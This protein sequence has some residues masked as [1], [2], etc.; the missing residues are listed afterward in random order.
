MLGL[1]CAALLG[2]P[3]GP[4]RL[5]GTAEKAALRATVRVTCKTGTGSGVVIGRAG[6]VAYVLTAAHV[7]AEPEGLAVETSDPGAAG[8]GRRAFADVTVV[9]KASP[10]RQDLAVL[11]V[12]VNG[13]GLTAVIP[14]RRPT[15][16]PLKTP[17]VAFSAGDDGVK[18][19]IQAETVL[20][21]A[22]LR[23]LGTEETT[24]CW[25]CQAAPV[26]G[27]S[28]GPLL[29]ADGALLGVCSGGDRTASYYVHVEEVRDF[30]K[31]NGLRFLAE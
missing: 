7:I 15:A 2:Q 1:L 27:R 29:D 4:P 9:A 17:A 24:R 21:T 31:R 11:R 22:R 23:H 5:Q 25:K 28:G 10:Q 12:R 26:P 18:V 13:E 8:G 30:L 14:L 3:A 20:G 6:P 16:A 19:S